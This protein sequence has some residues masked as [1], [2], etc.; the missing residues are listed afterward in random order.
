[1]RFEKTCTIAAPI[2]RL[3]N[4][5]VDARAVSAC[6]PGLDEFRQ[7]GTDSYEGRV[8]L[9]VGPISLRLLGR[10]VVMEHDR[11]NWAARMSAEAKDARVPGDV[12]AELTTRLAPAEGGT[13][14]EI[15]TEAKILG[16]L[17]EF[18]QPIMKKTVDKYLTQFAENISRALSGA[19]LIT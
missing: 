18:G 6:L 5:I 14:M 1:M 2:D 16:K 7:T 12:K 10:I 15:V 8:R 9:S 3:W 4:F 17:G 11:T 19:A 13:S